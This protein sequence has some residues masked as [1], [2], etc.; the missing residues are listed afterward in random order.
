MELWMDLL[1]GDAI[2]LMSMAVVIAT[3]V[4]LGYYA[5]MFISK[6]MKEPPADDSTC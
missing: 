4:L 2:G 1:F 3:V 6:A 5:W